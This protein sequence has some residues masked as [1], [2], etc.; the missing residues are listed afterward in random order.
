MRV[1]YLEMAFLGVGGF[2]NRKMQIIDYLPADIEPVLVTGFD[3]RPYIDLPR[4]LRYEFFVLAPS[5]DKPASPAR[6]IGRFYWYHASPWMKHV[7]EMIRRYRPSLIHTAN[8]ALSN[9]PA[10]FEARRHGIPTVGYQKGFEYRGRVERFVLRRGWYRHHIASSNS[11]AERLFDLGLP[12][13]KCTVMYEPIEPPVNGWADGRS[14]DKTPVVAMFSILQPWKGQHVFLQAIAKV[15]KTYREPFRVLLAGDAPNGSREYPERL[16]ALAAELGIADRINFQ[17]HVRD[18]FGILAQT[19]IAVHASIKPEPFGRVIAEA[20]IA[21][22]AVIAT[23]GGGAAEIVHHEQTGL[24]VPMGDVD[25]LAG[26]IERLLRDAE[27]RRTLGQRAREF[28]LRE[29]RPDLHAEKVVALYRDI[30]NGS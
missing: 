25:A 4:R 9:A 12:R 29:F 5:S 28:A 8:S 21:G 19:D 16:K 2:I 1:L 20:M 22:V 15:A 11:V 26:A 18:V 7:N 30:L 13:E 6:Q 14:G 3:A 17:G 10:A 23:R 24:H 27:L